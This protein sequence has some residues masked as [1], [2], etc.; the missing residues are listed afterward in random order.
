MADA[1]R[2]WLSRFTGIGL[3]AGPDTL[4]EQQIA[5]AERGRQAGMK[6]ITTLAPTLTSSKGVLGT[7]EELQHAP[8]DVF[9]VGTYLG[10]WGLP[11][12]ESV[13]LAI[14]E[15]SD[16]EPI[17]HDRRP[18]NHPAASNRTA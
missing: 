8:R 9:A 16:G 6:Q 5:A 12:E 17:N 3:H 15:A 11:P 13:Y 18:L 7:R 1:D 4:G 14:S 10:R 2:D